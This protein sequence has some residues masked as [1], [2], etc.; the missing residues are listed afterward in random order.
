MKLDFSLDSC[1]SQW[2]GLLVKVWNQKYIRFWQVTNISCC[3]CCCRICPFRPIILLRIPMK[4]IESQGAQHCRIGRNETAPQWCPPNQTDSQTISCNPQKFGFKFELKVLNK[5]N[6]CLVATKQ[7]L[8][9]KPF[10]FSVHNYRNFHIDH[11]LTGTHFL[12]QHCWPVA[13]ALPPR[14]ASPVR[15]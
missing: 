3:R 14:P 15:R 5:D 2:K 9:P 12:C 4:T 6:P 13:W 10:A 1:C 11:I 8:P 7:Y